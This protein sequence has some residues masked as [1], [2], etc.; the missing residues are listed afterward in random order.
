[1]VSAQKQVA[2]LQEQVNHYKSLYE[3]SMITMPT[4]SEGLEVGNLHEQLSAVKLVKDCLNNEN[5]DLHEQL[6]ALHQKESNCPT[7]VV[8]MEN[9]VNLVCL[10]CKHLALC[11]SCGQQGTV[12]KCPICRSHIEERMTI[13]MP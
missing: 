11:S 1:M 5:L 8:C 2:S 12:E 13:F 4:D 10:P 7:C 3:R 6:Q 9:L